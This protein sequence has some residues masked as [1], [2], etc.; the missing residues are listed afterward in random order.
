MKTYGHFTDEE[1]V[2]QT[3]QGD[4]DAYCELVRRSKDM[5]YGTARSIVGD[6][7]I[8]EDIAQD[9]FVDGYVQL[10]RLKEPAKF[11]FWIY[12][13]A[14]RKALHWISRRRIHEPLENLAET[15]SSENASPEDWL[16]QEERKAAIRKAVTRLSDKN[17]QVAALFY[18]ENMSIA[19]IACALSLSEG[20]VKSRLHEARAKLKGELINM[21]PEFEKKIKEKIREL[22]LYYRVKGKESS[23]YTRTYKEA[24]HMIIKLSDSAH[25]QSA[26]AT[27]YAYESDKHVQAKVAARIGGN[28]RVLAR[29]YMNEIWKDEK[30]NYLRWIERID[31]E[32]LPEMEQLHSLD[33]KGSLLFWRG[34]ANI[35]LK[36]IETARMDWEQAEQ[37]CQEDNIQHAMARSALRTLAVN[38]QYVHD[39]YNALRISA[40]SWISHGTK[41]AINWGSYISTGYPVMEQRHRMSNI[42]GWCS[43]LD[44]IL[45]DTAMETNRPYPGKNGVAQLTRESDTESVT[46]PAGAFPNCMLVHFSDP[47][48][49][50]AYMWYAPGIGLVKAKFTDLSVEE[51]YELVSYD[52]KGG[53]GY[54]PLSKGNRWQYQKTDMPN[55]LYQYLETEIDWTDGKTANVITVDTVNFK[56]D[57]LTGYQLDSDIYMEKAAQLCSQ[58]KLEA[59]INMLKKAVR[60]N[61]SHQSVQGALNGISFL[62]RMSNYQQKGYRFCPSHS[63]LSFLSRQNNRMLFEEARLYDLTPYRFGTRHEENR[64]FGAKPF[65]YL[66]ILLGC[67]WDEQWVPGYTKILDRT[68][69]EPI[70]CNLSVEEGGKVSVPA[71]DFEGCIKVTVSVEKPGLG[72]HEYFFS[73]IWCGTKEFWFAPGVG[74]VKFDFTWGT[75]LSSSCE[76][77]TYDLP[78]ADPDSY[79]PVCIGNHWEYD[80]VNLTEEGY[81]AK[82]IMSVVG[83]MNGQ[84]LLADNQEFL[85]LGTEMAYE[86]FKKRLAEG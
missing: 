8:A 34:A 48:N 35:H 67:V 3:L 38:E 56:K 26:L 37:L 39:P 49:Y 14:K 52:I 44:G 50:D 63:G 68:F 66:Q 21:N 61:S 78:A 64:I 32:A 75:D 7:T 65:R 41:F 9:T 71:G 10:S 60:E 19:Q 54:L 85:Y 69:G 46:V 55:Y 1:L 77:T 76:L 59:S 43:G 24:E 73:H 27:L 79:L 53:E 51:V 58:W 45:F 80:E 28:G 6:S 82:R 57:Y 29:L 83:G 70:P 15:L 16:I 30:D 2:A 23:D 5:V 86:S 4:N 22:S 84:Y 11:A 47:T 31:S 20:T 33:G 18:F 72:E 17:R 13:I 12:G 36:N 62:T 42:F 81:R 25:K 74:L 40:E